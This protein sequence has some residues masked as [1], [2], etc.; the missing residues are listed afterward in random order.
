MRGKQWNGQSRPCGRAESSISHVHSEAMVRMVTRR[1]S[2]C[3][4]G[5]SCSIDSDPGPLAISFLTHENKGG[6]MGY[7][8]QSIAGIESPCAR[9]HFTGLR[10]AGHPFPCSKHRAG[11]IYSG[12]GLA[13]HRKVNGGLR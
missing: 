11:R 5:N 4:N 12:L 3:D 13:N 2:H 6:A 8:Q 1:K 7:V 10:T 9:A